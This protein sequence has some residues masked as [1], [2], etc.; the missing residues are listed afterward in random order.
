MNILE[1]IAE[2][3]RFGQMDEENYNMDLIVFTHPSYHF[4][5]DSKMFIVFNI[6]NN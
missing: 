3:F 4:D 2:H 1:C 6:N 5:I